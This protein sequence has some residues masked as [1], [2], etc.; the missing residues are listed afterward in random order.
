[1]KRI[2]L[3]LLLLLLPAAVPAQDGTVEARIQY[4][5]GKPESLAIIYPEKLSA[6]KQSLD[7]AYLKSAILSL[8]VAVTA[9]S[10]R[11]GGTECTTLCFLIHKSPFRPGSGTLPE[12]TVNMLKRYRHINLECYGLPAPPESSVSFRNRYVTVR[13]DY[14]GDLMEYD[15][16]IKDNRFDRISLPDI[17]K[18][19]RK[20]AAGI[21]LLLAGI[22]GAFYLF[23][24]S[25]KR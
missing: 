9:G 4:L 24:V 15:I 14:Y 12:I 25:K 22:T 8:D 23:A 11:R 2:L 19:E 6:A 7:I 10:V 16:V 20:S 17:Y 21:V 13:G 5:K 18:S 1:M 3:L